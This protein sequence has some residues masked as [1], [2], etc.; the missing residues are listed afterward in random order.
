MG[1][2]LGLAALM[3]RAVSKELAK[4]SS[5]TRV[6]LDNKDGGRDAEGKREKHQK[7]VRRRG[8]DESTAAPVASRHTLAADFGDM[9]VGKASDY[10][11]GRHN[12]EADTASDAT[13]YTSTE[14]DEDNVEKREEN[15]N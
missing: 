1:G 4:G 2:G 11:F 10:I 8:T 15:E 13:I 6:A 5:S 12:A 14:E 9:G 7:K 3:K